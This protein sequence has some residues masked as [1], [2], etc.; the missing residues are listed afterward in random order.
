MPNIAQRNSAQRLVNNPLF[1][2]NYSRRPYPTFVRRTAQLGTFDPSL[3]DAGKHAGQIDALCLPFSHVRLSI[4]NIALRIG[5]LMRI[6]H[7]QRWLAVIMLAYASVDLGADSVSPQECCEWIDNLAV[8]ES[9]VKVS[10]AEGPNV[11]VAIV[12]SSESKQESSLP[13][14]TEED[15]FCCCAHMLPAIHFEAPLV[16]AQASPALLTTTFL[17]APPPQKK[18]HPPRLS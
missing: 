16:E 4:A 7:L 8:S 17:P 12:A 18:F 6:R 3:S 5:Y 10:S 13:S 15:C 2:S 1:L 11:V 9:S 14:N